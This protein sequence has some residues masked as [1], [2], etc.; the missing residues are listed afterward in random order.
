[1]SDEDDVPLSDLADELGVES[2]DDATPDSAD[3]PT[4]DDATADSPDDPAADSSDDATADVP[5]SELAS[6]VAADADAVDPEESPFETVDTADIDPEEAWE[7]LE[8]DEGFQPPES[9]PTAE[10]VEETEADAPEHVVDKRQ[11]CQQCPYLSS[12]PELSCDHEGTEIVE[13]R[14]SD[15]FRVRNCPMIGEDGPNFDAAGDS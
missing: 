12:P 5:L 3:D 8:A 7:R 10:P 14:D 9:E 15:N 13:V 2:T 11:Y 1:M 6:E 4:A